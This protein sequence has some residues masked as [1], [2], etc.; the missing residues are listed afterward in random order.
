MDTWWVY[1][2]EKK[3]RLYIGITTD[4]KN[5]MRQHG[6]IAPLYSEGPMSNKEAA[7]REK[8]LKGWSRKKKLELIEKGTSRRL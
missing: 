6:K 3:E 8:V 7:K 5:R 1:L 2:I 4:L